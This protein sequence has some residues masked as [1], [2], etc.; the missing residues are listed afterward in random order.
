MEKRIIPLRVGERL[1]GRPADHR[2]DQ[3]KRKDARIRERGVIL[4]LDTDAG[5]GIQGK[6]PPSHDIAVGHHQRGQSKEQENPETDA[7]PQIRTYRRPDRRTIS[8]PV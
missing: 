5:R 4:N 1:K 6:E 2:P 3:Q 7:P 8:N